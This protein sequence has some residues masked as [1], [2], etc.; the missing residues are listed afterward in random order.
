LLK[1]GQI[2]PVEMK[3]NKI[4]AL[5]CENDENLPLINLNCRDKLID[6]LKM[7]G[8]KNMLVRCPDPEICKGEEQII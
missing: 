3:Q 2:F 4:T 1:D 6:L 7:S 5:A 8:K